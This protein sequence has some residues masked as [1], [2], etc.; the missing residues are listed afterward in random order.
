VDAEPPLRI[1]VAAV[2]L[3]LRAGIE[4]L[5]IFQPKAARAELLPPIVD[6]EPSAAIMVVAVGSSQI[7]GKAQAELAAEWSAAAA[8]RAIP[9]IA[10]APIC[11]S[12][13]C[14]GC[15]FLVVRGSENRF[16]FFEIAH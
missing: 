1:A 10:P 5:S 15:D 6:S 12:A 9:T 2:N 11:G 16:P 14:S 4:W 3:R 7:G 8:G 13:S